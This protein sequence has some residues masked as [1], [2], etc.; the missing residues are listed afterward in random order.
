MF[1]TLD[2]YPDNYYILSS[3]PCSEFIE[4]QRFT[5]LSSLPLTLEQAVSLIKKI[6][7]DMEIKNRFL[8]VLETELFETHESFAS[9]PL[10]LSIMLLTF[11]NYAEIP[12]K[13]HLFYS[14]AFETLY[15]KHDATK[16]GYRREMR[17]ILS[18]DVFRNAFSCF[19]F[20]TYSHNK[21]KFS[22]DEILSYLSRVIKLTKV[23]FDVNDYLYD[24]VSSLSVLYSE[25]EYYQFAHRSF[26]EYF[27]A[28]FLKE[29]SDNQMEKLAMQLIR[30]D[31]IR[32]SSD[33][34]FSMLFDMAQLRFE[35]NILLPLLA[36]IESSSPLPLCDCYLT[37]IYNKLSLIDAREFEEGEGVLCAMIFNDTAEAFFLYNCSNFY[38]SQDQREK[39]EAIQSNNK[40][41]K[42]MESKGYQVNDQ[43]G[44]DSLFLDEKMY[45]LFKVTW[46]GSRIKLLS[47]LREYLSKKIE[48]AEDDIISLLE[49]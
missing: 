7:F 45:E 43:V 40:M 22:H 44:I 30:R 15:S 28:V 13:L 29:L 36:N 2:R 9:N 49:K 21:Y 23:S 20:I 42:Y 33:S 35:K 27:S 1:S 17:S 6:K 41:V 39:D 48:Q 46:Y 10:L 14:N 32:A 3:R 11:D 31:R 34:V 16:S 24:L 25:G 5:V 12:A 4:F 26:Q 19:C 38:M 18:Y 37:K 8:K 47:G